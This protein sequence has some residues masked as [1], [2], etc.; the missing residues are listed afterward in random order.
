MYY[1]VQNAV[2]HAGIVEYIGLV[3]L[4]RYVVS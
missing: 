3:T 4:K 2:F 1:N